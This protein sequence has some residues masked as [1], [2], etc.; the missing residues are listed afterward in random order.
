MNDKLKDLSQEE[1]EELVDK[2]NE[3]LESG[4]GEDE[5]N[6]SIF[7]M[8]DISEEAGQGSAQAQYEKSITANA[9]SI[10]ALDQLLNS[11][12]SVKISRKNLVKL[13]IATLKLPEEGATLKFGGTKDQQQ[14]C[15]FAFAQAQLAAN[16]RAFVLGVS[17]M[18]Q[19]RRAMKE[20]EEAEK[21]K[22][23]KEQE[24]SNE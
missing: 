14:M 1:K 19:Q 17:A 13:L 8:N 23:N 20:Q 21:Q 16:T 22:D 6:T 11:K 12:G 4:E 5:G 24:N 10:Y 3:E 15:E 2:V 9:Q 18:R 7:T